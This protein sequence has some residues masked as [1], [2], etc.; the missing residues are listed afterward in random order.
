MLLE[1]FQVLKRNLCC[2]ASG[3]KVIDI[4]KPDHEQR[5]FWGPIEAAGLAPLTKTNFSVLDYVLLWVFAER[6][7]PETSTFHTPLGELGIPLDDVQCLLHIPIEGKF[8]NHRKMTRDE[9][10]DMVSSFLG[11][12]PVVVLN[13]SEAYIRGSCF[14]R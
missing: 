14:Y 3:M 6:W 9:G 13:L 12:S 7:H 5:W 10:D 2:V 11:V 4:Q 1:L 8:L